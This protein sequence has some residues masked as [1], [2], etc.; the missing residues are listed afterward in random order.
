MGTGERIGDPTGEKEAK[1]GAYMPL[2]GRKK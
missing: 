1:K 2:N